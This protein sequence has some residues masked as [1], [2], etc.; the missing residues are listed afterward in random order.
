LFDHVAEDRVAVQVGDRD[1]VGR[2]IA[3]EFDGKDLVWGELAGR[4]AFSDCDCS[5]PP[6]TART[7]Q[8]FALSPG[9]PVSTRLV[10]LVIGLALTFT[11]AALSDW[12]YTLNATLAGSSF[13]RRQP[14]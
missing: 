4:I 7:N 6:T 14:M 8:L 10:L 2:V 5:R 13:N 11:S 12:R 3:L 1:L 9:A